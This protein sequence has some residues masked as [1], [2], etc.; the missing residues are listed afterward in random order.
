VRS[1]IDRHTSQQ[2]HQVR[3]EA[4]DDIYSDTRS[5]HQCQE[6]EMTSNIKSNQI[7]KIK[8]Q[9]HYKN[10]TSRHLLDNT[11]YHTIK[12]RQQ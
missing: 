5:I 8:T 1:E 4:L 3:G 10:V 11:S 7:Y 2:E 9:K 6:P 12:L